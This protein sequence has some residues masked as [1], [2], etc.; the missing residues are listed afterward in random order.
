MSEM[1]QLRLIE[2]WIGQRSVGLWQRPLPECYPLGLQDR[3]NTF[4]LVVSA[5]TI[6]EL[7]VELAVVVAAAVAGLEF[8]LPVGAIAILVQAEELWWQQSARTRF[9][10]WVELLRFHRKPERDEVADW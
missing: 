8:L 3:W 9:V 10:S 2:D 6:A 4:H 1:A 7:V 5:G